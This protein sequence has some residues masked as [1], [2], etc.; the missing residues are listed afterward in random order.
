MTHPLTWT[1]DNGTHTAHGNVGFSYQTDGHYEVLILL[2]NG[3]AFDSHPFSSL[4]FAKDFCQ[5]HHDAEQ[6][7][8]ARELLVR[9]GMYLYNYAPEN[10]RCQKLVGEIESLLLTDPAEN[11]D[12]I[13]RRGESLKAE[14][15]GDA[16][17]KSPSPAQGVTTLPGQEDLR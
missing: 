7:T 13:G 3:Q 1:D 4:D 2:R 10:Q 6:L 8:K 15:M 17:S 5:S 12:A 16:T 11:V 9:A 14:E